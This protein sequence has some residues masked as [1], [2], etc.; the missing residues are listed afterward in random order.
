[1]SA[2]VSELRSTPQPVEKRGGGR[3]IGGYAAV[4]SRPSR[5]MGAMVE[6]IEPR[7]FAKSSGDNFANVVATLEHSPR[8][9]LGTVNAG[10]LTISLDKVGM[11][12]DVSCPETQA[13]NDCLALVSRGDLRYS[14]F[15]F[16]CW[17]DDFTYNGSGL[18]VRHLNSVQV[19]SVSPVSNPAYLDSTVGL[20]SYE[21]GLR[22][23]A[24]HVNADPDD[25]IRDAV[26]GVELRRYYE[27]S[28]LAVAASVTVPPGAEARSAD[29]DLQCRRS[30]STARKIAMDSGHRPDEPRSV[31]Q[32]L[33]ELRI[34][35]MKWDAPVEARSLP[36]GDVDRYGNP[37]RRNSN[38]H[39]ID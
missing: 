9:L 21:A 39:A 2:P 16:R 17:E 30:E 22:S 4:F 35:R 5:Q 37:A 34:K 10:T 26:A 32:R 3:T 15:E 18:P 14:S 20:R 19:I 12:Y 28:D 11:G 33:L 23:F 36:V 31:A 8:D 1:M 7:A 27:R 25:V 38:G 6:V 13:G 24:R 29:L